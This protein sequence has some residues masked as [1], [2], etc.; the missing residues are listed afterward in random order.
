[1]NFGPLKMNLISFISS[2]QKC[3]KKWNCYYVSVQAYNSVIYVTSRI[4]LPHYK[5]V[6]YLI[7]LR[8]VFSI[9]Y[10]HSLFYCSIKLSFYSTKAHLRENYCPFLRSNKLCNI[11]WIDSTLQIKHLRENKLLVEECRLPAVSPVVA[12]WD[13]ME[14]KGLL[15][16]RQ[17]FPFK[18]KRNYNNTFVWNNSSSSLTI[19]LYS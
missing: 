3:L 13:K 12:I 19:L 11:L 2:S 7:L 16:N 15:L 1:M 17:F 14:Q 10:H 5:K 18:K 8:R 6:S 4:I 9:F